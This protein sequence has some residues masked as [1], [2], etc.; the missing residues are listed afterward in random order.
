MVTKLC[1]EEALDILKICKASLEH[2]RKKNTIMAEQCAYSKKWIFFAEDI[3]KFKNT[4]KKSVQVNPKNPSKKRSYLRHTP[5]VP[6]H[7]SIKNLTKTTKFRRQLL[8][9]MCVK[10]TVK[11]VKEGVCYFIH[12]EDLA[13]KL[14][15]L[16]KRKLRVSVKNLL[17]LKSLLA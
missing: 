5:V 3:Q 12:D 10:D 17:F 2:H 1:E 8:Y 7:T 11:H 14:D 6:G 9:R 15:E 4:L 13:Y 16:K